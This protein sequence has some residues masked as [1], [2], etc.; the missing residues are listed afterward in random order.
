MRL[1]AF[2]RAN[3]FKMKIAL[4]R[5]DLWENTPAWLKS[6]LGRGLG[7]IPPAWLFGKRFRDQYAFALESQWWPV[8]RSREYQ[9]ARLRG[10]LTSAY[11][12]TPFYR[13]SFESV[14]FSPGDLKTL[15]DVRRLPLID[16]D[17]IRENSCDMLTRPASAPDVNYVSTSGTSGVPLHFYIDRDVSSTEYAYLTASWKRAEYDIDIPM[18]VLRGQMVHVNQNGLRHQYDPI[19]RRHFY[20]SFHM[21]DESIRRYLEHIAEIGPCFLHVYP[22][23]VAALARFILRNRMNAPRNI[24]GII[25]ESEIVYPEQRQM[26]TDVFGCRYF[27]CYG[28][29]EKL[30]HAA[31][32]EQ[33]D[34]YHVWPTYGFFELLDAE[35]EPVTTPGQQGEIVGTGFM[36][37]AMPFI[38]YRT[39]DFATYV[40]DRCAA[41][42]REQTT[43]RDIQG[44][45]TQEMLVASDGSEIPW[46]A[47]NMHDNTF[48]NV[49]QFQFMQEKPGHAVLKIVPGAGF[50]NDDAERIFHNLGH[51][52]NGQLT[53]GIE[54]VDTIPLSA[55]AKTIYVDQRIGVEDA[56]RE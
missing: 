48:L 39:G 26:V 56:V 49:R 29:S 1:G 19:L 47:L 9:L 13:D 36:N 34:D 43:I 27:S 33:S 46:T 5:K 37:T 32:C 23:T 25:S 11:E 52:L 42:A 55:R 45:R 15:E 28:H 18:A 12:N 24:Q 16:K 51:K 7:L 44:H 40:S 2:A 4:S 3:F 31:G 17:V 35:G 50:R 41:C 21:S 10:I 6:A 30:V 20:C 14:G 54:L 38:R 22:S 8:E 53:L